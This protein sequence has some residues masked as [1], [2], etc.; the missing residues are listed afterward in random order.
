MGYAG[1]HPGWHHIAQL[2]D[3]LFSSKDGC[4]NDSCPSGGRG[5]PTRREEL[6]ALGSAACTSVVSNPLSTGMVRAGSLLSLCPCLSFFAPL[7]LFVSRPRC[8]SATRF[9]SLPLPVSCLH[10]CRCLSVSFSVPY[11]HSG[12]HTQ[13]VHVQFLSLYCLFA[14]K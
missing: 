1:L 8:P 4:G 9:P 5:L 6:L 7:D 12:I 10:V 13:G 3:L 2:A 14:G 11:Y